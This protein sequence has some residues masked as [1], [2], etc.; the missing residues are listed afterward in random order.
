MEAA[1]SWLCLL[2][3][4]V[5]YMGLSV[6]LFAGDHLVVLF[7]DLEYPMIVLHE[8]YGVYRLIRT[9]VDPWND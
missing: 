6:P 3:T 1:T 9:S 7:S 2:S 5:G 4:R 8:D